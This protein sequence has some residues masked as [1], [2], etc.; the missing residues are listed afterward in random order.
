MNHGSRLLSRSHTFTI[1]V[2]HHITVAV[3]ELCRLT[4]EIIDPT[5]VGVNK[6]YL[7]YKKF[8]V[9][10]EF[11]RQFASWCLN[12]TFKRKCWWF[13]DSI[14]D[15]L[16]FSLG[17]F[18]QGCQ[19]HSINGPEMLENFLKKVHFPI[20]LYGW[21]VLIVLKSGYVV[22][23]SGHVLKT[24]SLFSA[25]PNLLISYTLRRS[26]RIVFQFGDFPSREFATN[27]YCFGS[28]NS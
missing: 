22:L 19:R 3:C 6:I 5:P 18:P 16:H 15:M 8:S 4:S 26:S 2:T 12:I 24:T 21:N 1:I 20:L 9:I 28:L 13:W 14:Q 17:Q 11:L 7:A 27:T 25:Q 23:N 10:F